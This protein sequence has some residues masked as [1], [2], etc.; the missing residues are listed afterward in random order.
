MKRL[1]LLLGF[2]TLSTL[3]VFP[4]FYYSGQDP[5]SYRWQQI[6]TEHFTVVFP[7]TIASIGK[8]AAAALEASYLK[9]PY[10]LRVQP[11]KLTVV[12]HPGSVLSNA[13]VA[14]APRRM[15]FVTTPAQDNDCQDWIAQLAIHEYR[16][17]VQITS[18][19]RKFSHVLSWFF[20]EQVTAG[21]VGAFVPFWFIEGDATLSETLLSNAGRG[22]MPSFDVELR[23]QL[24]EKGRYSYDKAV[25]GSY[26]DFVPDHYVLGYHMVTMGR[27]EYGSIIWD[28]ALTRVAS[29]PIMITPFNNGIRRI[30]GLSK[31]KLYKHVMQELDTIWRGQSST[32]PLT[33]VQRLTKARKH[34]TKYTQPV[35]SGN[36]KENGTTLLAQRSGNDDIRR[37]VSIDTSGK[38]RKLCTPGYYSQFSL[39]AAKGK[40]VWAEMGYDPRWDN[41]NYSVIR[42]FD[43]EKKHKK[44]LS[45]RSRLFAPAISP[46]GSRIVA[47]EIDLENQCSLLVLDAVSGKPIHKLPA[48]GLHLMTPEWSVDGSRIVLVAG[49]AE[50]KQLMLADSALSQLAAIS[51]LE[52]KEISAPCMWGNFVFFS[53]GYSSID[54]IYAIDIT[55]GKR[56]QVT[57]VAYGAYEP[58]VSQDGKQLLFSDYTADGNMISRMDLD[59]S[60]WVPLNEPLVREPRLFEPLLSQEKGIVEVP[61]TLANIKVKPYRKFLH[62]LNP[63]SWGPISID[64]NAATVKPGL[65]LMS[66]N[67][68]STLLATLGWEY[69]INEGTGK[70]FAEMSFKQWYPVID[71]RFEYGGRQQAYL[72]S[73]N[74]VIRFHYHETAFRATMSVP[75]NFSSGKWL[76]WF[77]PAIA[78]TYYMVGQ[79]ESYPDEGFRGYM[80]SM[81]YSMYWESEILSTAKDIYPRWG[82]SIILNY[83][84]TPF[85]GYPMGD[86]SAI[87][88]WWYFPGIGHHHNL[89]FTGAW[90]KKSDT[91]FTF[92]DVITYPRGVRDQYNREFWT[93]TANYTM[94]LAY[95]DLHAGS[96][97][98]LK[99]LWATL[100]YDHAQ[101]YNRAGNTRYQSTGVELYADLHIFRFLAP[102]SIGG[103][104]SYLLGDNRII[105]EFLYSLDLQGIQ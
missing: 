75:F 82:Q 99:R 60:K 90:E 52:N 47:V 9:T 39:S 58:N 62:L 7:D 57:S 101:G 66:Q 40:V 86:I 48:P 19:N 92:S 24:L 61:D 28:T 50:G 31:V 94:T 8:K 3:Y 104:V 53:A 87:R 21:I 98:Y 2:F 37:I 22:R 77:Q 83:R 96:V 105:P 71:L 25:F 43:I 26:K 29:L 1:L 15:E 69:N 33:P 45:R 80:R 102:F 41:R 49:K 42:L 16:H 6:Q 32:M 103:R 27:R 63:H 30:S 65:T 10:S 46:D 85:D 79:M 84:H 12:L 55:S 95:P 54:N 64:A 13:F 11:H 78:T 20:G 18:V 97:F 74:N 88:T 5:A 70:Y 51:P 4:Q 72:D 14:W 100:F 67:K 73:N 44:K 36:V 89:Y 76:K 59:S 56:Y 38:I 34:Y 23:A 17:A 91:P 93:A 81:D 68:L 35:W